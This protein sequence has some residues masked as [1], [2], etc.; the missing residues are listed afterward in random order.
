VLN[1]EL[2]EE[3]RQ[4]E[5]REDKLAAYAIAHNPQAAYEALVPDGQRRDP[6]EAEEEFFE[7]DPVW[8]TAPATIGDPDDFDP[9]D[10][11]GDGAPN[12]VDDSDDDVDDGWGLRGR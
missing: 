5:R 6:D 12:G 9:D 11:S 2:D 1:R 8:I 3:E 4:A 10:I 7:T